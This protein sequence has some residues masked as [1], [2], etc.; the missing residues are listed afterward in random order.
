MPYRV[1]PHYGIVTDRY[2]L[3]HFYK[4]DVDYWELYD[5]EK[6]PHETRSFYNDPAYANVVQELHQELKRLRIE[7][8][9]PAE[10]PK[11]AYGRL[12]QDTKPK[13]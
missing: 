4:P 11:E 12:Y 8:K 10:A 5:R 2:K 6:D 9:V 7:L 3:V 1:R 13:P